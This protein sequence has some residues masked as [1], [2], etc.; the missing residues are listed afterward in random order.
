MRNLIY[1]LFI[2]LLASCNSTLDKS[3]FEPLT[4]EEL[5]SS[6]EKDSLFEYTYVDITYVRDS[7]LTSDLE[8]VKYTDLTYSQIHDYNLF[9]FDTTYFNPIYERIEKE[10]DEKF[11]IYKEEVDSVSNYWKKYIE[12]N[13]IEQYVLI[14]LVG[15]DKEYYS[16]GNDVRNVNLGFRLTPLKGKIEQVRFG[17]SIEAKINEKEKDDF[18][19]SYSSFLDKSWC[20]A[21]SPFSGPVVRYWEADYTNEKILKSQTLKTFLRDYNIHIEVDKI[22]K[23]GE[24]MSADDLNIPQA[25]KNHW[26]YEKREDSLQDLYFGDVVIEVLNK[27]YMSEFEYT[28]QEKVKILKEKFPLVS[29][30]IGLRY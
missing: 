18:Y 3:I 20:R 16:Y 26:K 8:K 17:Y 14:E 21:S 10:W 24:N 19:S 29:E 23:D 12:D 1:L 2:V 25:L 22:R 9:R 6:I 28:L 30:F 5:K 7:V 4:V 27:E 13:S 15:I 11:G